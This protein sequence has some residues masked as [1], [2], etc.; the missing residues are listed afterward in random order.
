MPREGLG[1]ADGGDDNDTHGALAEWVE[2]LDS[3][4]I[5]TKALEW[6]PR[7]FRKLGWIDDIR[8]IFVFILTKPVTRTFVQTFLSRFRTWR[9]FR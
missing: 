8:I 7:R 1:D 4:A 3:L 5:L 6:T 9:G 2:A